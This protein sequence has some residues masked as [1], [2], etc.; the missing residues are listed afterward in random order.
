MSRRRDGPATGEAGWPARSVVR[1]F[2][3]EA[4]RQVLDALATGDIDRPGHPLLDR[5]E[6]AYCILEHEAMHQETL[7]Y[8]WHRLPF[9]AEA[10]A[11]RGI[12]RASRRTAPTTS[13]SS[14]PRAAATLGVDPANEPFALGQ[15]AARPMSSRSPRSA[16][17]RHDVTNARFLEFV[18]AGGYHDPRWWRPATGTGCGTNG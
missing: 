13:G 1:Q 11:R 5:A 10:P 18:D 7:L 9:D 14:C 17:Q 12:G 8:M 15:R 4:D 6:A 3:A 2:A 16:S